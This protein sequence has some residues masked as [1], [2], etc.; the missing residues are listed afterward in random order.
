L[1]TKISIFLANIIQ[2]ILKNII[3]LMIVITKNNDSYLKKNDIL[4]DIVNVFEMF[5]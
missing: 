1:V 2:N 3:I 4:N 5:S